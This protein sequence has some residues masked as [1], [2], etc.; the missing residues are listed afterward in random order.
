MFYA[1]RVVTHDVIWCTYWLW[2][3]QLKKINSEFQKNET[4]FCRLI[5]VFWKRKKT[6]FFKYI[7]E[8]AFLPT[9]V[10][11]SHEPQ[12]INGISATNQ[13]WSAEWNVD[14]ILKCA[15]SKQIDGRNKTNPNNQNH[16]PILERN[17]QVSRKSGKS[18]SKLFFRYT[19]TIPHNNAT[20]DDK[21]SNY[22]CD[23][24]WPQ[25]AYTDIYC[26]P[27]PP[28]KQIYNQHQKRGN[29]ST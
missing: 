5:S 15:Y 23:K 3:S 24:R 29:H 20:E 21:L 6:T 7:Q 11:L 14:K 26:Y 16:P 13:S 22:N 8:K 18:I 9:R 25:T 4:Y 27:P 2:N 28:P 12:T 1:C 19:E 10:K 17:C